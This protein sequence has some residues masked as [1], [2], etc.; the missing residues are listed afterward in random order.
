MVSDRRCG[1]TTSNEIDEINALG[2]D[3]VV[4]MPIDTGVLDPERPAEGG[5]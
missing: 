4:G 5:S 2:I 1:I 3:A